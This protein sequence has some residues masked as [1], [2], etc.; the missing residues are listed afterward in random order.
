MSLRI[1]IERY[2]YSVSW[3]IFLQMLASGAV[4]SAGMIVLIRTGVIA[5]LQDTTVLT[6][7]LTAGIFMPIAWLYLLLEQNIFH[8]IHAIEETMRKRAAGDMTAYA[9]VQRNDKIG[10]VAK[11]LNQ[12]LDTVAASEARRQEQ[13]H[14]VMLYAQ[15]LEGNALELDAARAVA[16]RATGLKS[17]FLANMSHEIRTPMNGIIGMT[18]LL[19][20]TTLTRKQERYAETVMRSAEAL[21]TL[22]NDIL[23]FSKIES[24]KLEL[25]PVPFDLYLLAEDIVD[26]FVLKLREKNV[27][28]IVRYAPGAPRHLVGDPVRVRQILSNLVSNAAKFTAKGYVLL[29]VE[30]AET[31]SDDV[32]ADMTASLKVSVH[33]TG[34]GIPVEAQQHI[35]EK[36]TQ[37]DT[38]TT[39]RFGGTGLGLAISKQLVEMM[40]GRIGVTSKADEGSVFAFT[41]RLP[42]AAAIPEGKEIDAAGLDNIRVLAVDDIPVNLQILDEHLTAAG[43]RCTTCPSPSQVLTLLRDAAR[44]K[45]PFRIAV[46]DYMMPNM[47]G[48]NLGRAIKSDPML[49]DTA[50]ILLSSAMMGNYTQKLEKAGFSAFL[51]KPV[52]AE[53]LIGTVAAVWHG[54]QSGAPASL[55][56]ENVVR[57]IRTPPAGQAR[58]NGARILL[59]E[60][61]RVN[62]EFAVSILEKL[63]CIVTVAE[64]GAAVIKKMSGGVFDLILMDCHMPEMN[65]FEAARTLAIMKKA[66]ACP[67]IPIVALTAGDS[68]EDRDACFEAGMADFLVKPMRKESITHILLKWLP[69]ELMTESGGKTDGPVFIGKH[70]LLVEDNIVNQQFATEVLE[71][72]GCHV[73]L[74]GN[75]KIALARL[76]E[77]RDIDLILMDCQMPEM[78]GFEATRAIRALQKSDDIPS[79]PIVALTALAMKGDRERCIEAGMDDY[80]AKPLRKEELRDMLKKWLDSEQDMLQKTRDAAGD[81]PAGAFAESAYLDLAALDEVRGL[82]GAKFIS[83]LQLY[84]QD[85]RDRLDNLARALKSQR[86]MDGVIIAAHSIRSASAHMGA[87]RMSDIASAMETAAQKVAQGAAAPNLD[88]L[89]GQMQQIFMATDRALQPYGQA[90]AA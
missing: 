79:I 7:A 68:K 66:K 56:D 42:V 90:H 4:I 43:M 26:L 74:A 13:E 84:L 70:I 29:T 49:A 39:R 50:L 36:F 87:Q 48:E 30:N 22:I 23:D 16:E 1:F 73:T 76:Q 17:E 85:T 41:L 18:E 24:G 80:L 54:L 59:A 65:G 51:T 6:L 45:D 38:S 72:L 9:A 83:V 63:G 32:A 12:M 89:L 81:M 60:D 77:I 64:T 71:R 21:L 78:D 53:S 40:G 75:G 34:I 58:F 3:R 8:P 27:E 11:A 61:S 15:E 25:E 67:D 19:L 55:I 46:L 2:R 82:M 31:G 44:A 14:K 57:N 69:R 20:E 33:D 10:A 88:L 28:M 86:N 47:N 62:Q 5:N 37:A 52:Y 35:F